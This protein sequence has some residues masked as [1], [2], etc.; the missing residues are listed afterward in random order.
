MRRTLYAMRHVVLIVFTAVVVV[1]VVSLLVSLLCECVCILFDWQG[2]VRLFLKKC[3]LS[4]TRLM[5]QRVHIAYSLHC[6]RCGVVDNLYLCESNR[7]TVFVRSCAPREKIVFIWNCNEI[8]PSDVYWHFQQVQICFLIISLQK[9]TPLA[10]SCCMNVRVVEWLCFFPY[11]T[12]TCVS[13]LSISLSFSFT[14]SRSS[15]NVC[16]CQHF[17]TA[18]CLCC[19]YQM[20]NEEIKKKTITTIWNQNF[21]IENNSRFQLNTHVH[22]RI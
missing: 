7:C 16:V 10:L 22:M 8:W 20:I 6:I 18:T 21:G 1:V 4:T 17:I 11:N 12:Q 9:G 15:V 3:H 5:G 2:A 14:I 13:Y 19:Q